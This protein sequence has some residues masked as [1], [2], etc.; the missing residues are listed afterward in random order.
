MTLRL[1]DRMRLPPT[2]RRRRSRRPRRCPCP[3]SMRL[4]VPPPTD[5]VRPR[6]RRR[7]PPPLLLRWEELAAMRSRCTAFRR[8]RNT[9]PCR[10]C[11]RGRCNTPRVS[12]VKTRN[13]R[14]H[15]NRHINSTAPASST[16]CLRCKASRNPPHRRMTRQRNIGNDPVPH[17]RH[18][19]PHL[20]CHKPLNITLRDKIALLAYLHP[21]FRPIHNSSPR[22]ISRPGTPN[23]V[24]PLPNL[25][26]VP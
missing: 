20:E 2:P 23:L 16:A 12:P 8:M 9:S 10:R 19:P 26:P 11:S 21:I 14:R 5:S 3:V 24:P 22:N 6:M 13:G 15:S 4:P 17:P 25:I 7:L 18:C 1:T